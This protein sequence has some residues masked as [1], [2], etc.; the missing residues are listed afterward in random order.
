METNIPV[1]MIQ[2]I[3]TEQGPVLD[4]AHKKIKAKQVMKKTSVTKC[5]HWASYVA[6]IIDL[7][8]LSHTFLD[9]MS[10]LGTLDLQSFW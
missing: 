3:L 2:F 5:L 8:M 6:I 4:T 1:T 7:I 9:Q 10:S